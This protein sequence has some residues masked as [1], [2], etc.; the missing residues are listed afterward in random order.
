MAMASDPRCAS[1]VLLLARIDDHRRREL[2]ETAHRG[3]QE[4][5]A[6][7]GAVELHRAVQRLRER[8][9]LTRALTVT[10]ANVP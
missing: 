6:K 3:D 1:G 4:Q 8:H 7:V 5:R 9:G 2:G 10:R